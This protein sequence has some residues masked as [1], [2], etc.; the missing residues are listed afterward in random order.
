[1][2]PLAQPDENAG[3]GFEQRYRAVRAATEALTA[4]L[5]AEDCQVQSMPDAS[6]TKWHLAHTSWFFET[7]LL[8][9][10][11]PGYQCRDPAYALLFNSYYVGVGERFPRPQRGMLSRPSLKEVHDYRRHVDA[12]MIQLMARVPATSWCDLVELGL[13][14][15]QQHQE[16]I[17]MDI[18]HALSLNP[19][20][21]AYRPAQPPV[22]GNAPA[23][24]LSMPGG[25]YEI[26]HD[27]HGFAFDNEAPRHRVWLEPFEIA[28][29][30][31]TAG[32]YLRFI[33]D[34]GYRRPELWLSDGWATVEAEGWT[35]PLY[36]QE[37]DGAWTRF[38]LEGRQ[39][40]A[41]AAPL[42]HISY[43]EADAFA[44]WSGCRLPTE[45]E[46]E[47]AAV[48]SRL[49]DIDDHAWQW[50]ASPYVAY[51]GFTAAEGAVGEYNG[52][53]MVNQFALRGGSLATPPGHARPSY[54]NF[55]PPSARWVF[56]GIRLARN[57]SGLPGCASERS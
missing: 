9:P 44:R 43:Y 35:A 32:D 2:N 48:Q 40:I 12:A 38:S 10:L 15:E 23:E 19:L 7:F 30:L 55:F 3:A 29:R 28:D 22:G 26:G 21:P 57:S 56:A 11:L 33:D 52:K 16:L 53:F 42:L 54:R 5:S 14:H 41:P 13:N 39:P 36:W 4:P 27:G 34:G 46:W 1:M 50:T 8:A 18:Q 6:P 25:L 51:P 24:W 45:A 37:E 20:Q 49:R 17:L 31:V 47:A